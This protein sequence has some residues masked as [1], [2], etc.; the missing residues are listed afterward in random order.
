MSVEQVCE[1]KY[2]WEC[3]GFLDQCKKELNDLL[4]TLEGNLGLKGRLL[5]PFTES[6]KRQAC[7]YPSRLLGDFHFVY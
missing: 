1:H 2:L 5:W 6:E 4:G 7:G 3:Q